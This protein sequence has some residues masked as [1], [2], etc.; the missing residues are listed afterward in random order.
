MKSR[1][2]IIIDGLFLSNLLFLVDNRTL[3]LT[4]AISAFASMLISLLAHRYLRRYKGSEYWLA[5]YAFLFTAMI[6]MGLRDRIH[7]FFTINLANALL[8]SVPAMFWLGFKKFL[9]HPLPDRVIYLAMAAGIA[10]FQL[11]AYTA[12]IRERVIV[13]SAVS[14]LLWAGAALTGL[15]KNRKPGRMTTMVVIT[16]FLVTISSFLRMIFTSV[17][18]ETRSLFDLQV[19]FSVFLTVNLVLVYA[20]LGLYILL[21]IERM[22]NEVETSNTELAE[23]LRSKDNLLSVIGHDLKSPLGTIIMFNELTADRLKELKTSDEDSKKEIMTLFSRIDASLHS[24]NTL[25]SR[26][27]EWGKST[28]RFNKLNKETVSI[29]KLVEAAFEP[30]RQAINKRGID[31]QINSPTETDF[32]CEVK[33]VE[34][35]FRNL[36]SN[37]VKFTPDEGNIIIDIENSSRQ[38]K[39]DIFNEGD[40]FPANTLKK[41]NAGSKPTAKQ[42]YNSEKGSGMGLMLVR[43]YLR[44]NRGTLQMKNTDTGAQVR[45]VFDKTT[46]G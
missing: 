4:I 45:V 40:G 28:L 19:V 2:H 3:V 37:A 34:T 14:G 7:D 36:I 31:L 41:V 43:E 21:Y 13:Y 38:I 18:E 1:Y 10:V 22:V 17:T 30:Y 29:E 33:P 16:F 11:T 15:F 32:Y 20:V 26:L 42:G 44:P 12:T 8:L 27:L 5:G 39:V 6:L 9:N 25:L 46:D 35:V 24:Y 23:A